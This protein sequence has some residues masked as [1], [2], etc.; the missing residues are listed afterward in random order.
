MKIFFAVALAVCCQGAQESDFQALLAGEILGP[1]Q[2]TVEVQTFA[3]AKTPV[4]RGF[5]SAAAWQ[6]HAARMRTRL[7]DEV[8]LRGEAKRWSKADRKS[9]V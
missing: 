4:L 3:A 5:N 8:F 6:V 9:V 1:K 7:L 2:A